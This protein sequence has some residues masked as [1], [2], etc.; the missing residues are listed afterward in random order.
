LHSAS[1]KHSVAQVET[2]VASTK[3]NEEA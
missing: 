3:L 2:F 1:A